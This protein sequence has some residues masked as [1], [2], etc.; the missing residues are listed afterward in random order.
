M[1]NIKFFHQTSLFLI[2]QESLKHFSIG[3]IYPKFIFVRNHDTA[4]DSFIWLQ[5]TQ[6]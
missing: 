5:F 1:G 6:L 4:N 2:I 3:R